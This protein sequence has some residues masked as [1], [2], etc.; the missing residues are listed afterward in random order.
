[1]KTRAIIAIWTWLSVRKTRVAIAI[2]AA[3]LLLWAGN[4]FVNWNLKRSFQKANWGALAALV[5]APLVGEPG[6]TPEAGQRVIQYYEDR[7]DEFQRYLQT[8][9]SALVI[10]RS[11]PTRERGV[12]GWTLST[13]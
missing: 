4:L 11:A 10:A 2:F 8:W 12:E 13:K 1:M 7:P 3:A 6:T 5:E 9:Q